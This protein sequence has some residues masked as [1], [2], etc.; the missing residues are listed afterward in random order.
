MGKRRTSFDVFK[1]LLDE[2][3]IDTIDTILE[4]I[5][6]KSL[7]RGEE[8]ERPLELVRVAMSEYMAYS[9]PVIA[10]DAVRDGWQ[11][12]NHFVWSC[13]LASDALLHIRNSSIGTLIL[14]IEDGMA[15]DDAVKKYEVVVAPSN[16]K[17]PNAIFTKSMVARAQKD[18]EELGLAESL[19]RRFA[20]LDDITIND[21]L[22]ANRDVKE[23]MEG[24]VFADLA[25]E[26]QSAPKD[27]SKVETVTAQDFV[28]KVLPTA[29]TV[30]VLLENRHAGNMVSLIG[31]QNPDAAPLFK[32]NNNYAWAYAGNVT[33]GMREQV[34]ALGGNVEGVMRFTHSWNHTGNNQSLMDL[35]VFFPTAGGKAVSHSGNVAH[36]RYPSTR[37]VGWNHRTDQE[38]GATQDVDHVNAPGPTFIPIENISFPKLA[39]MPEGAYTFKI[40]NWS[41]RTPNTEGGKAEIEFGGQ[42]FEYDYPKPMGHHEWLTLATVT[43]K[44]GVFT[45][46]HKLDTTTSSR[47]MWGLPTNEFHPVRVCMK[48]PNHWEASARTGRD[49]T[50]FMLKGCENETTPN[51]FFNEFLRQDLHDHRKVFEA[52]GAKMKVATDPNQLSGVGFSGEKNET[53]TCRVTGKTTRVLNVA[54]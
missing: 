23:A 15:L 7:Y 28:L 39:G 42:V 4:L 11:A 5:A 50:F 19:P 1:R 14:N 32:W 2:V 21:I 8:W 36:E 46:D 51:G 18:V 41:K 27:F 38:S 22:F 17:R 37:R 48:S 9:C 52:L 29:E 40:H 54:F 47:V 30:E 13:V 6:Q 20:H 10:P 53:V 49:H 31:P 25:N 33:D 16:Y 45:I 43:L 34:R 3:S 26:T 35:H 24:D 12:H 44:D